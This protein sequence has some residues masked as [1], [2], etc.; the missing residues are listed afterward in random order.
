MIGVVNDIF[1]S[2]FNAILVNRYRDGNDC[3]L[4]HSDSEAHVDV[5]HGVVA[6][7][8]GATRKF[9]VRDLQ[10]N[11]FTDY[12]ATHGQLLQMAGP[13]QRYYKHAIPPEKKIR[14][15]RISFTFRVHTPEI[16]APG[17]NTS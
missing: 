1:G 17:K 2:Q 7:S 13:F 11:T 16:D 6:L 12:P 3:V 9:R 14:E 8:Y 10:T 4:E 15:P 5:T